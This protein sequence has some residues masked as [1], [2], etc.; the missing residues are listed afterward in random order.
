MAG[1][2]WKISGLWRRYAVFIDESDN[3]LLSRLCLG[4]RVLEVKSE[5]DGATVPTS[6]RSTAERRLR[7]T[8][9]VVD[10]FEIRAFEYIRCLY[11]VE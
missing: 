11:T 7:L 4:S 6:N 5:C 3:R 2:I 9:C 8:A 10:G 1:F